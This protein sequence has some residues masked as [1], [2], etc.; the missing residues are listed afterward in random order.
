MDELSRGVERCSNLSSGNQF[1]ALEE[2]EVLFLDAV[3]EKQRE[4]EKERELKDGEE[5]KSFRQYVQTFCRCLI[6]EFVFTQGRGG[7]R[8]CGETSSHDFSSDFFS[9]IETTSS[10]SEERR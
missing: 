9:F 1:R 4:E 3:R 5:L 6:T 10:Y 2:D 7:A 8:E